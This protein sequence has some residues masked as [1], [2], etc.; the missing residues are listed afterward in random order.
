MLPGLGKRL[1]PWAGMRS[2][3]TVDFVCKSSRRSVMPTLLGP[4]AEDDLVPRSWRTAQRN[5]PATITIFH[6]HIA[7][8]FSYPVLRIPILA[9]RTSRP[10]SRIPISHP[11]PMHHF[12]SNWRMNRTNSA[13]L[14]TNAFRF[15]W[16][17][18]R[19][20][21]DVTS[22]VFFILRRMTL[23]KMTPDGP[24]ERACY[25]GPCYASR[26]KVLFARGTDDCVDAMI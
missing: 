4:W 14:S 9:S 13:I 11:V 17:V 7:S 18:Q 2:E 19:S 22:D 24:A 3:Q 15:L 8:R 10:A 21:L 5:L 25:F 23:K 16:N 12:L 1:A 26:W 20:C 6:P